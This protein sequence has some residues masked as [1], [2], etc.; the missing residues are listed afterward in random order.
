MFSYMKLV[1]VGDRGVGKKT[2]LC[3]AL[4]NKFPEYI[5]TV[6]DDESKIINI[7]GNTVQLNIW[8]TCG[9]EEYDRMRPLSYPETDVFIIFFSISLHSSF[10]NVKERWIPEIKKHCPNVPIILVGTKIDLRGDIKTISALS[11]RGLAVISYQQ[12]SQLAN[13]IGAIKYLEC[14]SLN[15]IGLDLFDE[16]ARAVVNLN[17]KMKKSH[18]SLM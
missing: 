7:D 3:T 1:Y 4:S 2:I 9:G 8:G 17:K 12:G 13:E 11:E 5:P 18:C 14:S 6:F 10:E 15:L 16:S